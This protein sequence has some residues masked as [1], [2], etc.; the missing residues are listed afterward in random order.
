MANNFQES[1]FYLDEIEIN[2]IYRS[3]SPYHFFITF[4]HNGIISKPIMINTLNNSFSES[5]CYHPTVWYPIFETMKI[6]LVLGIKVKEELSETQRKEILE[7]KEPTI[8]FGTYD[9]DEYEFDAE[10]KKHIIKKK[11]FQFVIDNSQKVIK[12]VRP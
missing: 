11:E 3:L 9:F 4:K 7:I 5:I 12:I 8:I 1:P 6:L 2:S 10:Q